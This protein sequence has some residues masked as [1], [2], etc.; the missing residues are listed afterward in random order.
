MRLLPAQ[1]CAPI[2]LY[3]QAGAA[4]IDWCLLGAERF[5]DPFYTGTLQ[6]LLRHPFR[7]T[8]RPQTPLDAYRASLDGIPLRAPCGLVYHMSRCGSTLISRALA[9]LSRL[10]VASEP[11]ALD[12]VLRKMPETAPEAEPDTALRAVVHAIACDAPP[13][14][15]YLIKADGWHMLEFDRLR[16]ACP[17]TPWVFVYR[18]PRDVL[19]SLLRQPA[20]WM[21]PGTLDPARFGLTWEAVCQ[22]PP[23]EYAARILA[24]NLSAA[25]AAIVRG[26]GLLVHYDELPAAIWAR[27]APHFGL[28]LSAGEIASLQR[29]AGTDAKNPYAEF[30]PDS[31]SK[32]A[33]LS[34][35][36]LAICE[37]WLSAPYGVLKSLQAE[38][39]GA[40][41]PGS[42]A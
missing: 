7:M 40:A 38:P 30:Q 29:A 34:A 28:A 19:A 20:Y 13:E 36:A 9:Q 1:P 15:R 42:A 10:H 12:D 32:R 11:P 33:S 26:G 8:F 16:R 3:E 22:L 4:W 18:D 14:R 2:R 41:E 23:G 24:A 31:A 39:G 21:V 25:A 6:D 37:Q 5:T 35:G 27:I 17:A